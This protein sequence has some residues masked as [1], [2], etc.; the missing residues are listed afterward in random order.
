M[1]RLAFW[2]RWRRD[3]TVGATQP[4]R[5]CLGAIVYNEAPYLL[6]WLVY[7]RLQ[8]FD[9]AFV[10]DNDSNDGTTE[11]LEALE[12]LG[13][14]RRL[15]QPRL[16]QGN[17]QKM[18][19]ERILAEAS[20]V[21]S[22]VAFIDADEFLL[23]MDGVSTAGEAVHTLLAPEQNA[24]I[25]VNWRLFGSS[26]RIEPGAGLVIE[27]FQRCSD[28]GHPANRSFKS[29]VKPEAVGDMRAHR[30]GRVQRG[31]RYVNSLGEP[32]PYEATDG[33]AREVPSTEGLLR[34]N[35]YVVKSF[36]EYHER[37]A[38]RGT[39]TDGVGV[40]RRPAYFDNHD[41][42]ETSCTRLSALAPA[43]KAALA[44]IDARLQHTPYAAAVS[45]AKVSRDGD[46]WSGTFVLD[47]RHGD[48]QLRLTA[49]SAGGA[50]EH[51]LAAQAVDAGGGGP[52][53]YR[54]GFDLPAPACSEGWKLRV[55]GC[56]DGLLA[57]GGCASKPVA[58]SA[59]PADEALQYRGHVRFERHRAIGWVRALQ[60]GDPV[61][62]E[63]LAGDSIVARAKADRF[64]DD[65]LRA[66]K[67]PTGHCGFEID[68][69][70]AALPEEVPLRARIVGSDYE[71]PG[72]PRPQ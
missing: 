25:G 65:L 68:F 2:R 55:R 43:V 51:D 44:E 4:R 60:H 8:G 20:R 40:S 33:N 14:L 66:H 53:R 19:Y 16:K 26:G 34:V 41:R 61:E 6:E 31:R 3:D 50:S 64:R 10:G 28:Q 12:A 29:V 58:L 36:R 71:L 22:I 45:D 11:L 30:A 1:T 46:R 54:F 24:A 59:R 47:R 70:A 27:R 37:K 15:F 9:Y 57:A 42:N 32:A 56:R 17:A 52:A 63:I 18:V 62:I 21:P 7:H 69:D 49:Y 23:P 39:A 38:Y 5:L 13:W 67:H 35:H 48:L 72:T